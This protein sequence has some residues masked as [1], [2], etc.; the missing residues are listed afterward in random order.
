MFKRDSYIKMFCLSIVLV[1]T[2]SC[3]FAQINIKDLGAQGD[4]V[5]DDTEVFKKAFSL[6]KQRTLNNKRNKEVI[7]VPAGDYVV[8]PLELPSNIR[9]IFGD[10]SSIRAS[11]GYGL[12]DCV[13][14]L[15]DVE[16]I[17]II[18]NNTYLRMPKKNYMQG[19]WR[20]GVSVVGAKNVLIRGIIV[21]ETGGDGFYVAGSKQKAYSENIKLIDC[22]SFYVKRNGLSIISAK[23]LLVENCEFSYS[24]G[25]APEIG[26][27]IEPNSI[28]DVL[29][30][31]VIRNVITRNNNNAGIAVQPFNLIDYKKLNVRID[32][33]ID[34]WTSI[35]DG[36]GKKE[37]NLV[38]YFPH[39]DRKQQARIKGVLTVKNSTLYKEDS[40]RDHVK[41]IRWPKS[42]I[43]PSIINIKEL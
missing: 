39:D 6:A 14:I 24:S 33:R 42:S 15:R 18:G 4:G 43:K 40:A 23:K 9:I 26:I 11:S 1:M 34:N 36:V 16:N 22:K 7:T 12:G 41:Y 38:F 10:N 29:S 20:H 17:D 31:I 35:Y 30:G 21:D 13:F 27:D 5:T 2:V 32:V 3:S 8:R 37:G 19:E 28:S 25:T